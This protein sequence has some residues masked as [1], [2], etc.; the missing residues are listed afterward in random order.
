MTDAGTYVLDTGVVV[1]LQKS[2]HLGVLANAAKAVRLVLVEDVYDEVIA[3]R[4]GK[5]AVE[6]KE[7]PLIDAS[8]V[9]T[10]SILRARKL[11]TRLLLNE[12]VHPHRQLHLRDRP[13]LLYAQKMTVQLGRSRV[14]R[15][16]GAPLESSPIPGRYVAFARTSLPVWISYALHAPASLGS[17]T[18][19]LT[20]SRWHRTI[21]PMQSART[22]SVLVGVSVAGCIA[23]VANAQQTTMEDDGSCHYIVPD[24]AVVY[25]ETGEVYLQGTLIGN[26]RAALAECA[27]ESGPSRDS[28]VATG[29]SCTS[30]S[31]CCS[32]QC[33]WYQET[34]S[35]GNGP[36][37]TA[38][39]ANALTGHSGIQARFNELEAEWTV[40]ALLT[41]SEA[42]D[43]GSNI[44]WVGFQGSGS[45]G[46]IQPEL[47]W[48]N[49]DAWYITAAWNVGH[50]Y[51]NTPWV[52]VSPNDVIQ[53]Y[54]YISEGDGG[55]QGDTWVIQATDLTTDVTTSMS[56]VTGSTDL[57]FT[58]ANLG[59]LESHGLYS[60]NGLPNSGSEDFYIYS[61]SQEGTDW[62][63][64][65]S[66]L[67]LVDEVDQADTGYSPN[68]SFTAGNFDNSIVGL[69][70]TP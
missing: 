66:V 51:M 34:C 14:A 68:C 67:E 3:P 30:N 42:E 31:Q 2:G 15:P 55:G 21:Q 18:L 23:G 44:L 35:A 69:G 58:V 59:V 50:G 8:D 27:D 41:T 19:L 25:S 40:P 28:C 9:K 10:E 5:R 32:N 43:V 61:L 6:A 17:P 53:G 56:V 20:M 54:L 29:G 12:D 47:Y 60:C 1:G 33:Y 36:Y 64:Q 52:G 4:G 37:P 22:L 24:G 39:S 49:H 63:D 65:V 7:A 38:E 70:W 57:P 45:P 46:I 11:L 16:K 62:S 13:R 26:A 48:R